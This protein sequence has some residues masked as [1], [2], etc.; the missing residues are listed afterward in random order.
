[1]FTVV[2][3]RKNAFLWN[4]CIP[5]DQMKSSVTHSASPENTEFSMTA[6][7]IVRTR[8]TTSTCNAFHKGFENQRIASHTQYNTMKTRHRQQSSKPKRELSSSTGPYLQVEEHA[9]RDVLASTSLR[10]EGVESVVTA[11]D[12]LVAGHLAIGLD[13]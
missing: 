13:A 8:R 12:G 4:K 5:V 9:A 3:H 2:L 1:M 11:A 6:R 10:E 7:L